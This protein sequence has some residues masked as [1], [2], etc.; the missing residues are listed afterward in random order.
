MLGY[1]TILYDNVYYSISNSVLLNFP[2][3]HG[4]QILS[5]VKQINKQHALKSYCYVVMKGIYKHQR[6]VNGFYS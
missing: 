6:I 3:S 1:E 4:K 2:V 5:L